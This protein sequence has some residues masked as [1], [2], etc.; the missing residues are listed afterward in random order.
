MFLVFLHKKLVYTKRLLILFLLIYSAEGV[1]MSFFTKP[2]EEIV[3]GSPMEGKLTLHGKPVVGARM[4]RWI[5]WKDETGE[6]DTTYINEDGRFNL[7]VIKVKAKLNKI[8]QFVA[9][10]EINVSYKGNQYQIWVMG[11]FGKGMFSELNGK[12][13]NFRCELTDEI[14]RVETDDGLLGTSC[15]WDSIET[16]K[17]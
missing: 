3:L 4:V 10:Q 5:T 8:V 7:P 15:K 17:E 9:H 16:Y 1:A 6:T 14:R 13:I 12:P 2:E 11:K